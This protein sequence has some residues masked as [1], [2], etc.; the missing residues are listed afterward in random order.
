M[1]VD[2]R[3]NPENLTIAFTGYGENNGAIAGDGVCVFPPHDETIH[4]KQFEK[5][6]ALL[7]RHAYTHVGD[8]LNV[9]HR[10]IQHN[11]LDNADNISNISKWCIQM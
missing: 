6:I 2:R 11:V 7:V 9:V 1:A 8:L 3:D 10:C 5:T 4:D